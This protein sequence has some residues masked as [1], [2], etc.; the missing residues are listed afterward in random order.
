M[1]TNT[2]LI[3]GLAGLGACMLVASSAA[4]GAALHDGTLV[5]VTPEKCEHFHYRSKGREIQKEL[6]R[7]YRDDPAFSKAAGVADKPLNDGMIGDVTRG[8]LK[9]FCGA[10]PFKVRQ[11]NFEADVA[12]ELARS[13]VV[14]APVASVPGEPPD[15]GDIVYR[16]DPKAVKTPR[17]I[18]LIVARLLT[19][20][21]RYDDKKLFDEAVTRALKGARSPVPMRAN[22]DTAAAIDGYMLPDRSVWELKGAT[23]AFIEKLHLRTG[24][25]YANADD[26]HLDLQIAM[27]EGAEKT[28]LSRFASQIDQ[29]ALRV[30]YQIPATIATDLA[31]S[32][33]LDPALEKLYRSLANVA[34]PSATLLQ[35]ALRAQLERGLDMC[36]KNY[37]Q[38]GGRVS[39]DDALTLLALPGVSGVDARSIQS[40]R[41]RASRCDPADL[42]R[43]TSLLDALHK[44]LY[45]RLASAV[46]LSRGQAAPP[47]AGQLGAVAVA[48]C[49]CARDASLG[50]T[51]GF[52]P[53]WTDAATRRLNFDMLSR[54]GLVGMTVDD[55]GVLH[56]PPGIN[57]MPW[58]LLRSAY[59]HQTK[60][61]WVV[62][63][64]QWEEN[65]DMR[66]LLDGLR[67]SIQAHLATLDPDGRHLGTRV[68]SLGM[69]PGPSA[70]DGITL[71]FEDFPTTQ[72]AQAELNDF[73]AA[74]HKQLSSMQPARQLNVMVTQA[75]IL[76]EALSPQ[77][78]AAPFSAAHLNALMA[79]DG[80]GGDGSDAANRV[81]LAPGDI[82]VLVLLQEATTSNKLKLRSGIESVLFGGERR[83]ML[84]SVIPV[85]EFDGSRPDQLRDDI[86]YFDDNF[87]GIGFWPL[88]FASDKQDDGP[89]SANAILRAFSISAGT[90]GGVLDGLVDLICPNRGWLRWLAWGLAILGV[91][92]GVALATCRGCQTRL[93]A[94]RW[95]LGVAV[96]LTVLPLIVIAALVA[97][98]P[99]FAGDSVWHW[100]VAVVLLALAV[101]PGAVRLWMPRKNLP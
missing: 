1:R 91:A 63:K 29:L 53:L 26:F 57:T 59:Q 70:G 62:Y 2:V 19:L 11:D 27:G 64:D 50:V 100:V 38:N 39:D 97:G 8:W 84:R 4:Y 43:S 94:N 23:P 101:A 56:M 22:I 55:R 3:R 31:Q 81:T 20:T 74:L 85:V 61:D 28:E 21:A 24:T 68:A 40:L 88:P 87:G 9:T 65:G 67:Q 80:P 6:S 83:H 71:R 76:N 86:I 98:D 44:T 18:A 34:Y 15:G 51:Y 72:T 82:R 16:Y 79:H 60:V 92:A 90:D 96:A 45:A 10:H 78:D 66:G 46:D 52:Y 89:D 77:S 47:V 54:I 58:A 48:G 5:D 69:D 95:Y 13:K 37:R 32:A 17:D 93:D 14:P 75:Q 49:G 7:I 35:A 12:A 30:H 42:G 33:P 41:L 25:E 73:V 36:P 99:L